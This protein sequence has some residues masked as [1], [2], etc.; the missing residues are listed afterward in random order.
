MSDQNPALE[1]VRDFPLNNFKLFSWSHTQKGFQRHA[2]SEHSCPI[3][4]GAPGGSGP[5]KA[6]PRGGGA[7]PACAL[8]LPTRPRQHWQSLRLSSGRA[9]LWAVLEDPRGVDGRD[10]TPRGGGGAAASSSCPQDPSRPDLRAPEHSSS[11]GRLYRPAPW[12]CPK[13]GHLRLT[14]ACPPTSFPTLRP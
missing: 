10:H 14:T 13:T 8:G 9:A 1:Q 3:R 5:Q 4:P 7:N 12:V 11:K 2:E 6:A